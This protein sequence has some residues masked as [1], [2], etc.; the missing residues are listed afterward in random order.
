MHDLFKKERHTTMIHIQSHL[1]T[2][3]TNTIHNFLFLKQ[4]CDDIELLP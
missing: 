2:T 4:Q 1:P 3:Q